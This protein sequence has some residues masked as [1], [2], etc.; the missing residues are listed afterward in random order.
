MFAHGMKL[1]RAILLAAMAV[2]TVSLA[3]CGNKQPIHTHGETEGAYIN[4]GDLVYQVQL[5]RQLNPNDPEDKGYLIDLPFGE[6]ELAPDEA[7]FGVFV[8]AWNEGEEV[9]PSAEA[10]RITDTTGAEYEPIPLGPDNVF[11]YRPGEVP[12]GQ[13]TPELDSA[14]SNNPSINGSLLLFRVKYDAFNN[15]PLELAIHAPEGEEP[16]EGTIDLDV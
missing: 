15:R 10:F 6:Q 16:A 12:K 2:V 8:K 1:R 3:A 11:A 4:V 9:A 7:W 13:Q 5:S 14:A